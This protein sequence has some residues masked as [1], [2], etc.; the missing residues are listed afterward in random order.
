MD[1]QKLP[2]THKARRGIKDGAQIILAF[3]EYGR[4]RGEP[5]RGAHLPSGGNQR[6]SDD[7]QGNRVDTSL[8]DRASTI[9]PNASTVA[10]AP[11]GMNTVA[12]NCV[13]IL[14]AGSTIPGRKRARWKT[15]T[16]ARSPSSRTTWRVPACASTGSA[17]CAWAPMR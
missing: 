11:G 17:A 16:R 4:H 2:V 6:V 12:S 14:G 15:G 13:A 5:H 8:H 9:D 3:V 1:R 7:F 10:S